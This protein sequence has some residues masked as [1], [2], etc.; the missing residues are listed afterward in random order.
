VVVA[1]LLAWERLVV[2][3]YQAARGMQEV[4]VE[5]GQIEELWQFGAWV[6]GH[7]LSGFHDVDG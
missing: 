7:L 1:E 3:Y 4:L 6:L 2:D 5:V